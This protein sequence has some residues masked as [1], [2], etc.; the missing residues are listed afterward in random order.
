M[1]DKLKYVIK[2]LDCV[3]SFVITMQLTNNIELC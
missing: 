2:A 3:N 1:W